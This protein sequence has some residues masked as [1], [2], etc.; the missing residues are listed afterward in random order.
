MSPNNQG[1]MTKNTEKA[2]G[3]WLSCC[4]DNFHTARAMLAAKR[5][6]FAMFMCQQTLESLLKAVFIARNNERP[7]YIHK[8]PML[9]R[10][11]GIETPKYIDTNILKIDAHYIKAR[12]KDDRFNKKI[13]NLRTAN[14]LLKDTQQVVEWFAKKMKLEISL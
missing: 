13:Y 4:K 2:I 8:L 7:P 5:Y 6:N 1:L 12:Y 10:R 11:S 9:V 14:A 3:F